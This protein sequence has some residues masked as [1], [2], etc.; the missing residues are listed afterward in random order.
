LRVSRFVSAMVEASILIRPLRSS[1]PLVVE[2]EL[3]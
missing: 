1:G 3:G 2:G